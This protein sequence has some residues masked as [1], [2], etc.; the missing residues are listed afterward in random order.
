M[1]VKLTLPVNSE[2]EAVLLV[3]GAVSCLM[4]PIG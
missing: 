4:A 1:M 3:A 2:Q